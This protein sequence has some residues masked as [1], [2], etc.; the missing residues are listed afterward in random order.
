[1][2]YTR[3]GVG[4][5]VRVLGQLCTLACALACGCT[6]LALDPDECSTSTQC[7][8]AFGLGSVC[9]DDGSCSPPQTHP[10]CTRSWPEDLLDHPDDYADR[11]VLGSLFGFVDHADTQRA[12]E[13]ALRQVDAQGGLDGVRFAMVHCDTTA[14]AG[15]M[16][17]DV[18]GSAAAAKFLGETIGVPAIVGPRGSSRTQ[19]AFEAVRG[20]DV[21]VIS[22]SATS[23]ALT[24]L[25]VLDPTFEMPG[26]LWRTVPPD[27]L[28]SE[29]IAA[30]M[31][32][33][34]V[35]NVAAIYQVGAYGEGLA[36]L[37]E[38][39]F[40]GAGGV[41]VERHP[42]ESGQFSSILAEVADELTA[43]TIDEVLFVSSDIADYVAMMTAAT[44][45]DDLEA[46]FTAD[47]VGI[48]LADAAYS[49]MLI[50]ETVDTSSA[51]FAKIRGT[52]PAPAEGV[53]FNAFA[54]AYAAEFDAPADSSG[55]TP[56]SYDA[57]W[58]VLYGIARAHF[59]EVSIAGTGIARGLRRISA[60]DPIDIL[61]TSWPAAVEHFRAGESIDVQGASGPLDYDPDTEETT[62]PIQLWAIQPD[63]EAPSG[64][65]FVELD[66]IDPGG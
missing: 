27:T 43:G 60:G 3:V 29:V 6:L 31:R 15:D 28:Q 25:D 17:D 65:A 54:A 34:S 58:L 16:L 57:A 66:R 62:A 9:N 61:P 53:L 56:H 47:G 49:A 59:D 33:R 50:D 51:L 10:R 7:R 26:L 32:M 22:P 18:E 63:V 19:A 37:F 39:R 45:T 52:R 11:V 41:T 5:D 64:F 48:F 55:F 20:D 23:P 24:G 4:R 13:L 46:A 40:I 1:M 36:A 12:A 35:M 42:F 21:L 14:M 8:A 44:A 30:D 2:A 38:D